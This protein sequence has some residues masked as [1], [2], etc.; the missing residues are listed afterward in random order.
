MALEVCM[1]LENIALEEEEE[2]LVLE[3]D[4]RLEGTAPEEEKEFGL[5]VDMRLEGTAPEEE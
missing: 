1:S 4:M 5:E 3:V 2:E